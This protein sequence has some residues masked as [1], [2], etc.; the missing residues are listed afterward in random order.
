MAFLKLVDK[1]EY[2]EVPDYEKI[3]EIFSDG[4]MRRGVKDDGKTVTFLQ[5]SDALTCISI[6]SEDSPSPVKVRMLKLL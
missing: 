4:L 6:D 2:D 5:G 1:L 3:K